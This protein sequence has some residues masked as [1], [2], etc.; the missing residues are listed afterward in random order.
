[1]WEF[2]IGGGFPGGTSDKEPA[3]QFQRHKR[4]EFDSW[5]AKIPWRRAWQPTPVFLPGESHGQKSLVGY[6]PWGL[7]ESDMSEQPSTHM[8][9]R[10][11][12]QKGCEHLKMFGDRLQDRCG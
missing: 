1:M 11:V 8:H 3:C 2:K 7:K 6:S 12:G 4:C 10:Q 5:V 9:A